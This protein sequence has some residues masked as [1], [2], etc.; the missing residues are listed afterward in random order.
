MWIN[1]RF[2]IELGM[3]LIPDR[4]KTGIRCDY[5]QTY[6]VG[7]YLI[8]GGDAGLWSDDDFH[9]SN[10]CTPEFEL[11]TV[12]E[13]CD[14]S[15]REVGFDASLS[16]I[17][18]AQA[19]HLVGPFAKMSLVVPVRVQVCVC[20][21]TMITFVALCLPHRLRTRLT[22]VQRANQV[23]RM[24]SRLRSMYVSVSVC[25]MMASVFHNL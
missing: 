3:T 17:V 9:K 15:E 7:A 12:K 23:A 8:S 25:G 24:L 13:N 14:Q 11:G 6:T 20:D 16:F 4:V 18:S 1:K 2:Q 22:V 19:Y 21:M 10:G 5:Q